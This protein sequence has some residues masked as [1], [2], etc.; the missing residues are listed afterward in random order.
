MIDGSAPFSASISASSQR[1]T[2]GSSASALRPSAIT[3]VDGVE[4][5]VIVIAQ[6]ARLV[7]EHP[8][9]PRHAL[10]HRQDLVDLLLILHRG[11]AHLGMLEHEGQFVG[12]RVGIDRHRDRAEHLRRHQRPV[13]LRPVGADD[14]DGVAALEAEPAQAHR[15][16]AHDLQHLAPGPGL[17]DAEILV[18]HGRPRAVQLGVADQK[19]RKCLRRQRRRTTPQPIPPLAA[20]LGKRAACSPCRAFERGLV[21]I[22]MK[23]PPQAGQASGATAIWSHQFLGIGRNRRS[24]IRRP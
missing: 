13:E 12:H 17:P 7:I 23:T 9:E 18:P 21:C 15:I 20:P 16:G 24:A 6:A 4:A 2:A 11:E 8:L 3:V 1:P 19:L 14:G 10:H 5:A 22:D